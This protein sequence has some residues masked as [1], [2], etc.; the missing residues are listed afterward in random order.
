MK[1]SLPL[2]VLAPSLN[3]SYFRGK[4][5][6]YGRSISAAEGKIKI[7]QELQ[8]RSC[9]CSLW[10]A[11]PSLTMHEKEKLIWKGIR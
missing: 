11:M 2:P 7:G 4:K 1:A 10:K 5:N 9:I 8:S 6:E 3:S